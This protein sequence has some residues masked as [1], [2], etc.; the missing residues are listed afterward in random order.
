MVSV[1]QHDRSGRTPFLSTGLSA[2]PGRLRWIA[3]VRMDRES[4]VSRQSRVVMQLSS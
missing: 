2:L 4:N 1:K 3:Y